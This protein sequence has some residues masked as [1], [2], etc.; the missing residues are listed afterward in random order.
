[1]QGGRG[2]QRRPLQCLLGLARVEHGHELDVCENLL[3]DAELAQG[4]AAHLAQRRQAQR[5]RHRTLRHEVG[6]PFVDADREAGRVRCGE[7][8]VEDLVDAL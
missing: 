7:E 2:F 6:E 5:Q 8:L 1:M 3:G 4:D